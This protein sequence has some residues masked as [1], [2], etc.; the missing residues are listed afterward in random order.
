MEKTKRD[1]AA[2][3]VARALAT[4]ELLR[5]QQAL[6]AAERAGLTGE[7]VDRCRRAAEICSELRAVVDGQVRKATEVEASL[8]WDWDSIKSRWEKGGLYRWGFA[9]LGFATS[10]I[11]INI[12]FC[13]LVVCLVHVDLCLVGAC[14]RG[15]A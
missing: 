12:F 15:G 4:P 14:G 13:I 8:E 7:A 3:R 9:I 10:G 6:K 5:L 2:E 11:Y 1:D